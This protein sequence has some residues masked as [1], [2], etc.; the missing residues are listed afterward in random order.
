MRL[1]YDSVTASGI[2]NYFIFLERNHAI[3]KI[4][5]TDIYAFR[6][7]DSA[8][9]N[10][11]ML[12]FFH[13]HCLPHGSTYYVNKPFLLSPFFYCLETYWNTFAILVQATLKGTLTHEQGWHF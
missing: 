12:V 10:M 3:Y 2:I 7:S 4:Y 13:C 5:F 9:G 11:Q 1:L 6:L 8:S